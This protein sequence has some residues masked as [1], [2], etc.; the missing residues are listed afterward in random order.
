MTGT[1]F[2]AR[3]CGRFQCSE[4]EYEGRALSKCLY[5]HARLLGPVLSLLNPSLFDQDRK[6]VRYLGEVTES[7]DAMREVLTFQDANMAHRSFLRTYLRIRASGR[8]AKSLA[9]DL[10]A[11]EAK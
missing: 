8:K 9:L 4:S 7:R 3:F 10:F 6:L 5:F 2:K 11:P 1:P